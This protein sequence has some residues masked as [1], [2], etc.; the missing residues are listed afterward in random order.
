[1]PVSPTRQLPTRLVYTLLVITM[2]A[3]G[4]TFVAG[5][6]VAMNC[7]PM[8]GAFWRFVLAA[9][10]LIPLTL[11]KE[12]RLLPQGLVPSD[13][14]IL[15]LLGMS[16]MFGYNFFFIKGLALTEAGRASVI[17][18]INP[19]IT[20]LGLVLFFKEKITGFGIL[21]FSCALL[22]AAVAITHGQ[23]WDLFSGQVGAGELLIVGCTLCWASY[24]LLGKMVL[25]H[26]SPLMSTTWAC[27]FGVLLLAPGAWLE[28]GPWT[29]LS[30]NRAT[31]LSLAFLGAFGTA[32]GFTLYYIGI[33]QLGTRRAAI[34]I[35]L[36]PMFGILS[37][38]LLLGEKLDWSLAAGLLLVLSG[39]RLIQRPS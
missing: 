35:N 25:E 27:I 14:L 4:G 18:A 38:W 36:V 28:S 11:K 9:L 21:G 10:V 5:R 39:I 26:L 6:I 24:S 31:W 33:V 15:A 13:W 30:F 7:G 32:L 12:G 3:W 20:Y 29:F 34:F 23:V 2:A 37:G 8:T 1:M 16:G 19:S 22:G 17:V